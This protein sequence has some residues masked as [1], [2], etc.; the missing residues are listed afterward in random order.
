MIVSVAVTLVELLGIL[1]AVHAAMNART[2]RGAIAWG[3]SLL[4]FPWIALVLYAIIGRNK[5]IICTDIVERFKKVSEIGSKYTSL[6]ASTGFLN[7]LEPALSPIY[8]SA[9]SGDNC[10][11]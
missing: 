11:S 3:I 5:K 2:S 6:M 1:T 8:F 10:N 4:T 7:V 9:G